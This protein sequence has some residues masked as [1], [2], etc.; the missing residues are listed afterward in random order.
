MS[1]NETNQ[2]L[3]RADDDLRTAA[4]LLDAGIYNQVCFHAQ[5]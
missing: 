1:E 2:W 4:I 3:E 5:Q